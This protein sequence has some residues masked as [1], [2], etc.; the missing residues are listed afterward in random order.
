MTKIYSHVM[1]LLHSVRMKPSNVRKKKE[2]KEA[3]NVTK[4]Q[5]HVM[6]V[7][8]NVRMIPSNVIKNKGT[9]KCDKSTVTCDIGTVQCKDDTIKCEKKIREPPNVTKVQS[10]VMLVLRN[11]RMV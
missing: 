8:H 6:L 3:P 10:H 7:L 5:S 4:V 1:L 9:T 2:K 11:V